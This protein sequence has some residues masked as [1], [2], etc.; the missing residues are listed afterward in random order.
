MYA[1]KEQTT[2]KTTLDKVK[3]GKDLA[4]CKDVVIYNT[5]N[6]V[7]PIARYPWFY[8]NKPTRRN[9]WVTINCVKYRLEWLPDEHIPYE[10]T[11]GTYPCPWCGRNGRIYVQGSYSQGWFAFV[12]CS[13]SNCGARG[14][15]ER[16]SGYSND[17]HLIQ[18]QAIEAWN[19][20]C[21]C[22]T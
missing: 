10:E 2:D 13:N 5:T 11:R 1:R 7:E 12:D 16:T 4:N 14:P 21:K 8:S 20:V 3:D 18:Q 19:R 22:V 6:T 9:K 17:E 15:T